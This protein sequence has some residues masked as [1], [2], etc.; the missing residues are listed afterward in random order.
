MK[1][2]ENEYPMADLEKALVDVIQATAEE[3][4]AISSVLNSEA[5]LLQKARSL[6]CTADELKMVN[7]SVKNVMKNIVRLQML[8]QFKLEDT[9]ELLEKIEGFYSDDDFEEL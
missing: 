5:E 3:D 9:K 7:D 6:Y 8:M 2:F 1:D 4:E